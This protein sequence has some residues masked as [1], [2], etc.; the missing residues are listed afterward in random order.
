MNTQKK[1]IVRCPLCS[2]NGEYWVSPDDR[3]F[4]CKE[5][6]QIAIAK[7]REITPSIRNLQDQLS[8][9]TKQMEESKPLSKAEQEILQ[10]LDGFSGQLDLVEDAGIIRRKTV[11]V[12]RDMVYNLNDADS[13]TGIAF[14]VFALFLGITVQEW[15]SGGFTSIVLVLWLITAISAGWVYY[16]FRKSSSRKQAL[17]EEEIEAPVHILVARQAE[18]EA[19]E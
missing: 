9:L 2:H 3:Y 15:I 7:I 13:E 10:R 18:T 17:G 5:H 8:A 14:G 16:F 1:V 4:T 6:G 19:S 11:Y 12:P